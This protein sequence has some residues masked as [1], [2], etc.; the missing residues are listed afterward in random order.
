MSLLN[1]ETFLFYCDSLS[2]LPSSCIFIVSLWGWA[3]PFKFPCEFYK[4]LTISVEDC[5]LV[6]ELPWVRILG[7]SS[8]WSYFRLRPEAV[9][10]M[11]TRSMRSAEI[12]NFLGQREAC[13]KSL[14]TRRLNNKVEEKRLRWGRW[15]RV[16]GKGHNKQLRWIE[17]KKQPLLLYHWNILWKHHFILPVIQLKMQFN[18]K[19]KNL[20]NPHS[21]NSLWRNPK[22]V[23]WVLL[24]SWIQTWTENICGYFLN[25]CNSHNSL[26]GTQYTE[27]F[28]WN[29]QNIPRSDS[30]Y[31]HFMAPSFFA[32]RKD[33]KEMSQLCV[34]GC[35]SGAI[36]LQHPQETLAMESSLSK[37]LLS[38]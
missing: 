11:Y 21:Y 1:I 13:A 35:K 20:R 7:S 33:T 2:F 9:R 34:R 12:G 25:L 31:V 17:P 38:L 16:S 37:G 19:E 15:D 8:P 10:G 23:I 29:L 5:I 27:A 18:S 6:L 36:V 4:Q 30:V 32:H 22:N 28:L 3:W 14:C 26:E 24:G